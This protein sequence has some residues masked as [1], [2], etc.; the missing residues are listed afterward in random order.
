MWV[1]VKGVVCIEE[2]LVVIRH[3]V[4]GIFSCRGGCDE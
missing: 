2:S 3:K 1:V 4:Q